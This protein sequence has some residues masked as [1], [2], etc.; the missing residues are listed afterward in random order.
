MKCFSEVDAPTCCGGG[1]E[2]SS[3]TVHRVAT[4]EG[5]S[6]ND[7][8]ALVVAELNQLSLQDRE[9]V[10]ADIHGVSDPLKE[11]PDFVN[12]M[13]RKFD[14]AISNIPGKDAYDV[15][16]H[17]SSADEQRGGYNYVKDRSVHI[18]F[19]RAD[20]WDPA[21]SAVRYISFLA[22]KRK[23]FG[24]DK[25]TS[26][27]ITLQDLSAESQKKIQSGRV[28]VLPTRDSSERAIVISVLAL[29]EEPSAG[30]G[31]RETASRSLMET[32]WYVLSSCVEDDDLTQ[33]HGITGVVYTV[34]TAG[35]TGNQRQMMWNCAQMCSSLPVKYNAFHYCYDNAKLRRIAPLFHMG[36]GKHNRARF[37]FHYGSHTE[38]HYSLMSYGIPTN[39]IPVG[40]DGK[41]KTSNHSKW[42][43]LRKAKERII[44]R[45][46]SAGKLRFDLIALPSRHDVLLGR[47][48]PFQDFRGNRQFHEFLTSFQDDYDNATYKNKLLLCKQLVSQYQK[49][50]TGAH[51]LR[52]EE[53]TGWWVAVTDTDLVAKK[54]AHIFRNR[55]SVS[56]SGGGTRVNNKVAA[57]NKSKSIPSRT[58]D[59]KRL[60]VVADA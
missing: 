11:T 8:D 59:G 35:S 41:V 10:Y 60:R 54:V 32:F 50:V 39:E 12:E 21:K 58:N 23:L 19:L 25:L 9:K 13:C 3:Q 15:A 36:F 47:G 40:T 49:D 48:K 52:Q 6:G 7:F 1:G 44:N 18:Q 17:L 20:G 43:R 4:G 46:P 53:Q 45:D 2:F 57:T 38:C 16:M 26:R 34:G 24:N 22:W 31:N 55:R 42:V 29:Q 28:Q 51:F 14:F 30:G 56:S 33:Q 37:K 27:Y 5:A